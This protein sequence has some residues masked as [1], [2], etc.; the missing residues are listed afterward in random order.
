MTLRVGKRISFSSVVNSLF[1]LAVTLAIALAFNASRTNAEQN[2]TSWVPGTPTAEVVP[3]PTDP[4]YRGCIYERIYLST[5]SP[6]SSVNGCVF[7]VNGYKYAMP[8]VNDVRQFL[9]GI[10]GD[11]K[12]YRVAGVPVYSG[13][14]AFTPGSNDL[15]F[16]SGAYRQN[17][18]LIVRDLL[19]KLV[20]V[21]NQDLSISYDL[22]PGSV[23]V[24][25]K[26][27]D[28][29]PAI[30]REAGASKDGKW[31]VVEVKDGGFVRINT[32]TGAVKWYSANSLAYGFG[33][34]PTAQFAVSK[35]GKF[36]ATAG[37]NLDFDLTQLDN[38]CGVQATSYKREWLNSGS[39]TL[40][41]PCPQTSLSSIAS[42]ALGQGLWST[43]LPR[44]DD[45]GAELTVRAYPRYQPGA[46]N[47]DKWIR[48]TAP[49]YV[50]P[51][52]DYLA[53]G[54]SISSGE[55]DTA[56]DPFFG[57]KHYRANTDTEENETG[58]VPREKCHLSTRSYPYLLAQSMQ[59]AIN[60]QWNSVA[61]SGA[62][63][64]DV[65]NGSLAYDGQAKGGSFFAQD[66]EIAR[67]DGYANKTQ[68]QALAL[69]EFIPGRVE[70]VKFIQ[71][72]KP[73]IITLTAGA[74]SIDFAGKLGSCLLN[75]G[76]CDWATT[77]KSSLASQ[78]QGQ[79]S[80]LSSLYHQLYEA[81]GYQA[82]IYV[83]SYPQLISD[84][85]PGH[86]GSNTGFL[87][88]TER[89]M[90]VQATNYLNTVIEH[91]ANA[92][93]VQ[94]VDISNALDDGRLCDQGQKYVTGISAVGNNEAQETF[95]PNHQGHERMAQ[96]IKHSTSAN[97]LTY[98][99][100][101]DTT[102]PG[103]INCPQAG[104]INSDEPSI[105]SE[106][107]S[108]AV[109]S[110]SVKYTSSTVTKGVAEPI[111][112]PSYS[113]SPNSQV[114]RTLHS[115]P[116]DLGN[117]TA[118]ASGGINTNFTVPQGVPAGYHTLTLTGQTYSGEP[119]EMTQTILVLGTNPE[120]RDGNSVTDDLQACGPFLQSSGIDSDIDGVDDACDSYIDPTPRPIYRLRA[121]NSERTYQ[122]N[123]EHADYLYLERNVYATAFTGVSGD[124][125]SDNDG[126]VIIAATQG[127]SPSGRYAN[128]QIVTDQLPNQIYVSFRTQE[129]G[130]VKYR[131][132]D[133]SKVTNS[134][135]Y[136]TFMQEATNSSACRSQPVGADL[137]TDGQA[138]NV[139]P[140]YMGRNGDPER[141]EIATK[142]YLFRSTR[143]AEAQIGISDYGASVS[144]VPNPISVDDATDYR[145]PWSLLASTQASPILPTT[146][147]NI[148]MVGDVPYVVTKTNTAGLCQAYKPA[149][150]S[151]IQQ[152]TQGTTNLTLDLV[153]T[154]N[155]LVGGWCN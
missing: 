79:Y 17:N 93:G 18:L 125:D 126:Y 55:G 133:L 121:G 146:Y 117:V 61:C 32:Q 142:L 3:G 145:Q 70:Q 107:G 109:S 23:E 11:Q 25:L 40:T 80:K 27:D 99:V 47:V 119:I 15:I 68:L 66:N 6:N 21:T 22:K 144:D 56:D 84:G 129:N 83:I 130:C 88:V 10:P 82:K 44:F 81:S 50:A 94:Y 14:F 43:E 2:E 48:V 62:A 9:V 111:K 54:D 89:Q 20:R 87:D 96:A 105:P 42:T 49:S 77:E 108:P 64:A 53:L 95:H 103:D 7:Y 60:S 75:P 135:G 90:I 139:Q 127:S 152:S 136:R 92:A 132:T 91:A 137:D 110:R 12:M 8:Y 63:I 30:I 45:S 150:I 116:V 155:A 13:I 141:G 1:I 73:K 138:D 72:Y 122:G 59:L 131:P 41:N 37:V 149:N 34:D 118:D 31:V 140:L 69:N 19:S 100:C 38:T 112:I 148:H 97:L 123:S 134:S 115:D 71:K 86:C 147:R 124:Y 85:S 153:Q 104:T 28:G 74:N 114:S 76:T 65:Y 35:D 102:D 78:I 58:G 154:L 39:T 57:Q 52:L 106:F 113:L 4:N 143:A 151:T 29:D 16:W 46:A 33:R 5:A 101:S 67:L 26:Y 51:S 24:L 128:L 120:D 98:D 36:I